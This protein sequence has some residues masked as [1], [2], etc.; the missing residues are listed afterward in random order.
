MANYCTTFSEYTTGVQPSDWT[1]RWA[2][3]GNTW[4]V[5]EK[6]G[7]TG[8]KSLEHTITTTA[9]RL[10]SWDDIDV[11]A[12]RDNSEVL[13]RIRANAIVADQFGVVIRGSGSEGSE[14][15]YI[16]HIASPADLRI[17]RIVAGTITSIANV[18]V[19]TIVAD[20]WNTIRFRADG[21]NLK[22]KIWSSEQAQEPA[23]WNIETTDSNITS[24]GWVGVS[25]V[26]N[27]GFRDHDDIAIA[28]NSDTA[29]FEIVGDVRETQSAM[30]VLS[31]GITDAR[32]TQISTLILAEELNQAPSRITQQALLVMYEPMP[33]A[34]FTQGIGLVLTEFVT[35]TNITQEILLVLADQVNCLTRWAQ[36]WTITRTDGEIFAFTSHDMPVLFRGVTHSPCNSMLASAV[37]LS[38]TV[39]TSGSQ[40]LRGILSDTGISESDIYNGLYDGAIIESWMVPWDNAGGEIPFRL[41]GGVIGPASFGDTDFQ[42][43]ILTDSARLQQMALLETYTPACRYRFGA[44]NDIRCPVDLTALIVTG[45][46]TNLAIPNASTSS[47]R[48]IFTDSGRAEADGYF[49]LGKLTWNTGANAGT[50]SEIKDFTAGQFVLWEALLFPIALTDSYSATP[51]CDKSTTDHLLFNADLVDF[52][53]FPDVP[54]N[55]SILQSPD[56]KG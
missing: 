21:I 6:A 54:G 44:E 1:A 26:A 3:S 9:R 11:D 38:T 20:E 27:Y 18:S 39:G 2:T 7:D 41:M 33:E 10:L 51:G 48:R 17:S 16:C 15:G 53:G 43:E 32:T 45:S 24:A 34:R 30:L 46:A 4:A 49:N 25:N 36:T 56:A 52:G 29:I 13:L 5:R 31:A 19:T 47:T 28:T 8:G 12:D 22:A 37:E 14:T 40:E 23:A 42:Q 50:T 35:G 55:D